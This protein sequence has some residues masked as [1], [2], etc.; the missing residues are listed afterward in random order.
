MAKE[1]VFCNFEAPSWT[2]WLGHVRS[3]H[4]SDPDFEIECCDT[5]YTKCSSFVSH[6]Y[7]KHRSEL[8]VTSQVYPLL[9]DAEEMQAV[10]HFPKIAMEGCGAE[11][12]DSSVRMQHAV[13]Q[14]LQVDDEE[15][16][17]QSALFLLH[18]KEKRCLSQA[19]VGDVVSSCQRLF[20]HTIG[21]M[22]AGI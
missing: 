4:A 2:L 17:K 10:P 1:C 14:L 22:Q 20:E 3:V 19:A 15:Q 21:R 11:T 13:D 5:K 6:V 9:E 8:S 7:R 16:K 18:L 12:G